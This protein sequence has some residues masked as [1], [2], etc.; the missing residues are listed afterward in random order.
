MSY[1]TMVDGATE[2]DRTHIP[3]PGSSDQSALDKVKHRSI[4][5][6][7]YGVVYLDQL[8]N[9]AEVLDSM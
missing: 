3:D 4:K 8:R 1:V 6:P 9:G 2:G 5:S 7:I